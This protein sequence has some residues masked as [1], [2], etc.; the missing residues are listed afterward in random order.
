MEWYF[1]SSLQTITEEDIKMPLCRMN[2]IL[3]FKVTGPSSK[4]EKT[5]TD[6]FNCNTNFY[7]QVCSVLQHGVVLYDSTCEIWGCHSG[8]VE[9]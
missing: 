4:G 7:S 6:I 5:Q 2:I 9:D 8:V 1:I 3:C